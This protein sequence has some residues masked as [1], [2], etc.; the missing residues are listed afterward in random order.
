MIGS[1]DVAVTGTTVDDRAVPL[2]CGG[3]WQL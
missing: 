1:N 2:L 3:D